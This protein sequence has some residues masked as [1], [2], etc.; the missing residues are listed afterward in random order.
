MK[1]LSNHSGKK[2]LK[3]HLLTWIRGIEHLHL[4]GFYIVNDTYIVSAISRL[5]NPLKKE[6][7]SEKEGRKKERRKKEALSE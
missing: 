6:A 2:L 5:V 7:L 4:Y 1:H 3:K